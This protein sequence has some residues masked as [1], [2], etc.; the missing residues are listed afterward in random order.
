MRG[1]APARR[2]RACGADV[3]RTHSEIKI[4]KKVSGHRNI[5]RLHDVTTEPNES[6]QMVFEFLESDLEM[7]IQ[8]QEHAPCCSRKC[9][10]GGMTRASRRAA[11]FRTSP[12]PVSNR[13]F[14]NFSTGCTFSTSTRRESHPAQSNTR[15]AL[16][17]L[18]PP[19]SRNRSFTV[20]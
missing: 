15:G 7:I 19:P 18:L 2:M 13:S 10:G 4:L 16:S 14:T 6:V 1:V 3:L 12:R 17:P 8:V 11:S 20:T 5:V 9:R